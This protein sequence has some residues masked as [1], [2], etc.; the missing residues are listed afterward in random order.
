MSELATLAEME[1]EGWVPIEINGIDCL[2]MVVNDA[3]M[4]T[5][6]NDVGYMST[7]SQAA[8]TVGMG[9]PYK[10]HYWTGNVTTLEY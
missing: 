7:E 1:S 9:K 10:I 3:I 4:I 8:I 6:W 2:K 5:E